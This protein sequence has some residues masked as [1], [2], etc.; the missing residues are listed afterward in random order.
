MRCVCHVPDTTCGLVASAW[1]TSPRAILDRPSRFSCRGFTCGAPGASDS[2]TESTAGS[3]S[4]V[5][6]TSAAA[7]RAAAAFSAATTATM[8]P[9]QRASSPAATNAGQSGMSNPF[10]RS[11]GTSAA[12]ATSTTPGWARA[13][14]VSIAST[15]ARACG[16]SVTAPYNIPGTARSSTN[17]RVPSTSSCPRWIDKRSP[18]PP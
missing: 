12:V 3:G 4:Y 11:P 15:R 2:S 18:T 17:G 6:A 9:T 16:E 1:S 5:T 10:Q 8:S 14:V 13:A 7:A